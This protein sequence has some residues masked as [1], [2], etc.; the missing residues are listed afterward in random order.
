LDI[1]IVIFFISLIIIFITLIIIYVH[2]KKKQ[3]EREKLEKFPIFIRELTNKI[4]NFRP[5]K[6]YTKEENFQIELA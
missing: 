4:S 1:K 6:H 3:K 5:L 2:K